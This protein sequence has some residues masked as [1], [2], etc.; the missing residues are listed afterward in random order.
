M[1]LL[2]V[3]CLKLNICCIGINYK[4]I[5]QEFRNTVILK[6][7]YFQFNLNLFQLLISCF[8]ILNFKN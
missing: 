5:S 6:K 1:D 3:G 2:Y 7:K 8:K 4:L